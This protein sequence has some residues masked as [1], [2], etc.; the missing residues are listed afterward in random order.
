VI[1]QIISATTLVLTLLIIARAL[2][3]WFPNIDY[4]NPVVEFLVTVTEPILAPIRS[5]MP[6]LGFLDLTPM[7][8]I[9]LINVIGQILVRGLSG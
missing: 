5:V 1:A 9:I 2:M 6:R 3:S 8:A 4:R 7:V